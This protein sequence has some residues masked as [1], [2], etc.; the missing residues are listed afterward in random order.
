MHAALP[1]SSLATWKA[2]IAGREALRT[3]LISRVGDG[4]TIDV[5]NDKWI[6]GTI[7]MSPISRPPGTAIQRVEELIDTSN[8][9][10]KHEVVR[11]NFI[12]PDAEAILNIPIRQGG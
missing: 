10:W 12:A 8:W 6:P 7:S 4:T 2:I 5:W 9:T 3:G 1:K 11:E